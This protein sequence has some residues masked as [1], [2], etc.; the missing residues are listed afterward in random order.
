MSMEKKLSVI[1]L[2]IANDICHNVYEKKLT[3]IFSVLQILF[4]KMSMA[5]R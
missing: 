3:G 2:C 4:D 5:K 1:F